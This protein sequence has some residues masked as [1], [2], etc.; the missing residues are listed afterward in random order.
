MGRLRSSKDPGRAAGPIGGL[1]L[2]P[3]HT[4]A[5][6]NVEYSRALIDPAAER[7]VEYS[8]ALIDPATLISDQATI[9]V[10]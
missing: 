1:P 2:S 4:D 10:P 8:C 6:R 7:N 3:A 9:L 5:E